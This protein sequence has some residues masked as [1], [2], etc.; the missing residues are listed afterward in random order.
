MEEG[1]DLIRS[2]QSLCHR[3]HWRISRSLTFKQEKFFGNHQKPVIALEITEADNWYYSAV[4][5]ACALKPWF[6]WLFLMQ[7]YKWLMLWAT[8]SIRSVFRF[9]TDLSFFC[10]SNE[11]RRGISFIICTIRVWQDPRLCLHRTQCHAPCAHGRFFSSLLNHTS[12]ILN[13]K[14]PILDLILVVLLITAAC[15]AKW[16]FSLVGGFISLKCASDCILSQLVKTHKPQFQKKE[17]A[18]QIIKHVSAGAKGRA[19]FT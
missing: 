4:Q 11:A 8:L 16:V 13:R 2:L 6:N 17:T 10:T 5:R 1:P 19:A 3:S 12:R 7:Q 9:V 18:D 15:H 14:L